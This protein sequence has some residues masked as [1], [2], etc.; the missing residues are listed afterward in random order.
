MSIAFRGALASVALLCTWSALPAQ[1]PAAPP[2]G[3]RI[4]FVNARLVLQSM[5]GYAQAESTFTREGQAAQTEMQRIQAEFDSLVAEFQQQEPMLTPSNRQARRRDLE[6]KGQT[7]QQQVQQIQ[8]R[9]GQRERELLEPMQ[10]RMQAVIEGLRAEGNFAMV[11]DLSSQGHGIIAFDRSL[12][13]TQRVMDR[14][15][16]SN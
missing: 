4:A 6:Q 10:D 16:Q 13:I 12:D 2:G 15:R 11:V 3:P 5:P 14:L 7:A 8:V 9:M 1:Q